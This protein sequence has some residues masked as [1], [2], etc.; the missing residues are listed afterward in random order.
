MPFNLNNSKATPGEGKCIP[1]CFEEQVMRSPDAV[2]VVSGDERLTYSQLNIRA[3]QL[4]HFLIARG[5]GPETLVA[6]CVERSLEMIVGLLGILKAGAAYVPLDPLYPSQ[7]LGLMLADCG[8]RL[9][10][11]Q[12]HLQQSFIEHN[13]IAIAL[14]REQELIAQASAENPKSEC[15]PA[16][17][18]YVMYTSGS[19]GTPKGV[20]VPHRGIVR[21]VK[22]TNYADFGPDQIFLQFAPLS[23]D[24]ST[25]EIWGSLLNG[26]RLVLLPPGRVSLAERS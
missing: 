3:N 17:L 7:R 21:L 11:T 12:E 5:V 2:A 23:F 16:N 9:V 22:E 1:E 13:V 6:I 26:S 8:A 20:T 24:A 18:A 19:T 14:D 25:F 10:L 15:S 4:A